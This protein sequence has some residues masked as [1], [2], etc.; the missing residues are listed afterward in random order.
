MKKIARWAASALLVG[1]LAACGGGSGEAGNSAAALLQS[2]VPSGLASHAAD[3]ACT[4]I[5]DHAAPA[6][7]VRSACLRPPATAPVWSD[8]LTVGFKSGGVLWNAVQDAD[9]Y[10]VFEDH[11]GAGPLAEALAATTTNTRYVETF[12][13]LV[14]EYAAAKVRVRACNAAGCGPFNDPR[15][16]PLWAGSADAMATPADGFGR[17]L[18]LSADG[19]TLAVTSRQAGTPKVQLFTRGDTG[20]QLQAS[21]QPGFGDYASDFG[22]ALAL[23]ADGSTLAIGAPGQDAG[24]ADVGAVHVY[25]RSADTWSR[26]ASV[27]AREAS[28][29]MLF[30]A[31]VALS[32]DG[33]TLAIGAPGDPWGYAGRA[34]GA[35]AAFV[36]TRAGGSWYQ[37]AYLKPKFV[38]DA[39]DA[40]GRAVA[41]TA[42]GSLLAVGA[43]G[44]DGAAAGIDGHPFDNTATD[45]GA[46]YV[47]AH[48]ANGWSQQAYVKPGNPRVA[49][50]FGAALAFAADGSTLAV[51]APQERSGATGINGNASDTSAPGAGAAYLFVRSAG[52]WTQ[53][54]YV[55]PGNT[56][57][58]DQFGSSVALSGDGTRLAVG[59]IGEAG[60]AALFGG[61]DGT[62]LSDGNLAP[63]SGAVYTF[64]RDAVTGWREKA[65]LKPD[66][67]PPVWGGSVA[68]VWFGRSIAFAADGNTLVAGE[69]GLPMWYGTGKVLSY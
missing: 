32:A 33:N 31:S 39:G 54:A 13:G 24:A 9:R 15:G 27:A 47:F 65:Y 64:H 6:D 40:F 17:T 48:D 66:Q 5:N 18:A 25:T 12:T 43:P 19:R 50:S 45:S 59:A 26:Q 7:G 61:L 37:Q 14:Y 56:G 60:G 23:S 46:A 3:A 20:W 52:S 1:T 63:D 53:S 30:G 42:D 62:V 57:A 38:V 8:M 36:F 55:K 34:A 69:E 41:L 44:E 67:Q 68:P 28:A 35:G 11:D 4:A 16:L 22:A 2:A 10:E 21:L 49:G 29:L 58:G 51:G